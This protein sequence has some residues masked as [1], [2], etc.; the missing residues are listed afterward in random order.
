MIDGQIYSLH[1]AKC[2]DVSTR[3][4]NFRGTSSAPSEPSSEK[5]LI[6]HR[7]G[8]LGECGRSN[9]P[10]PDTVSDAK[11]RTGAKKLPED[12]SL[13]RSR[14]ALLRLKNSIVSICVCA[15]DGYAHAMRPI[16]PIQNM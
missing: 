16:A 4:A 1:P 3:L 7:T 11:G 8:G 15:P 2:V 12:D 14:L 9:Y 13:F 5:T 10:S 6:P